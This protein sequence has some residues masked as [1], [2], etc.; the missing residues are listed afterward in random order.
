MLQSLLNSISAV[1]VILLLAVLGYALGQIGWMNGGAKQFLN[2]YIVNV[3]VPC[4]CINGLL[5]NLSHDDLA[6]A[7]MMVVSGLAGICLSLLLSEGLA[8]LLR[9]PHN[10]KGVFVAMSSLSNTL[11]VGLPLSTELFGEECIPY[12]MAYYLANTMLLQTAGIAVISRAGQQ[13][14]TPLHPLGILRDLLRRPP[15][16][17]VIAG[18]LLLVLDLELPRPVMSFASYVGGSVAPLA[19]IYCGYLIYEIGL[20]N[21]RLEQGLGVMLAMRF[22]VS[23]AL[24]LLMC[25]IFGVTGLARSVFV[26]ESALPVVNQAP[27]LASAYGADEHYAAM[28]MALSTIACFFVIPVLMLVL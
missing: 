21:L 12:V 16:L 27:V 8:Q 14:G 17:A 7:G 1:L 6:A 22:V 23:P 9:L 11:N 19:L 18:T 4:M 15:V 20:R 13:E 28:G 2:K 3:A 5:T 24:C 26:V 25:H 10:R